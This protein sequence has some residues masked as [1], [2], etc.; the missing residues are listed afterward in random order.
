MP[1]I[2]E[3]DPFYDFF[4]RFMPPQQPNPRQPGP[5]RGETEP[6][7]A[8]E[9]QRG[10]GSGFI[11]SADG[12]VLT[13]AHVVNGAEE[14]YVTLTDKREFK[15]KLI[16]VDA[17]TDV[18]V[19]KVEGTNLPKVAIGTVDEVKVGQWVIAIGSPFGLENTVTAGIVS[20]MSRDTGEFLRF[21]QTDVAVNPGNSG[22][23]LLNMKGEVIGINSQIYSRTGGFMGISFAIPIDEAINVADQIRAGG[24]VR[25][26][27]IGVRIGEVSKDVADGLGIRAAGAQVGLVESG[28]PAD[29]AG[30]EAGDIIV[31]WQGRAIERSSDLPRAVGSTKPGTHASIQVWR[32]GKVKDLSVTVAELVENDSTAQSVPAAGEKPKTQGEPNSI[33]LMVS[34]L[35]EARKSELRVRSGVQVEMADGAAGRAGIRSGDVILSINSADI[36]SAKQFN[37]LVSKLDKSKP[38]VLLVRRG[39]GTQF[40]VIRPTQK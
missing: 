5:R 21:I 22:G 2:D 26:G 32:G 11:I 35:N 37:D 23:P 39:E 8:P 30:I 24:K 27:R 14:I 40:I 25:R 4:R 36:T 34:D 28:G 33:G 16:G 12:Y 10:V 6:N 20:A 38:A 19:V 1:D 31:K 3:N 9:V 15:G 7:Q 13:N 17:K 29:K 18:A